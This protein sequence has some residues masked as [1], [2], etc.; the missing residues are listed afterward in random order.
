MNLIELY[1]QVRLTHIGLVLGSGTLFAMRGVG[2]L[3]GAR[4]SMRVSV[5]RLSYCID[6]A[7]L[8]AGLL[9]LHILDINPFSVPWLVTKLSLLLRYIV[10]GP[11]ALKRAPTPQLR[12]L[13]FVAALLCYAY[14]LG[15]AVAHNPLGLFAIGVS[16]A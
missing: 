9:L 4:W 13:F 6:T 11:L 12:L 15:V 5:R 16:G 2:V 14:M 3:L 7:L 8:G 10:L 1:P